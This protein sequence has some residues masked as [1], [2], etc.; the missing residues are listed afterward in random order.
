MISVS[1]N[2]FG[3]SM[4]DGDCETCE[5]R[6]YCMLNEFVNE[7]QWHCLDMHGFDEAAESFDEEFDSPPLNILCNE[8]EKRDRC[9]YKVADQCPAWR[10]AFRKQ[11]DKENRLDIRGSDFSTRSKRHHARKQGLP[12]PYI[13]TMGDMD[14]VRYGD[15]QYGTIIDWPEDQG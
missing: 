12:V 1:Y 4:L 8:C 13:I 7:E 2:I 10:Q 11:H 5:H 14:A 15:G 3:G 9:R 6:D